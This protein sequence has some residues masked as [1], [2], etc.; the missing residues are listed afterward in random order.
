MRRPL[1]ILIS[2]VLL[3]LLAACGE[4]EQPE[5]SLG[6]QAVLS[7]FYAIEALM[8]D[9]VALD[10]PGNTERS[11]LAILANAQDSLSKGNTQAA[12]GQLGAFTRMVEVQSGKKILEGD[13]L[14]LVAS[15]ESVI[16]MVG[17]PCVLEGGF[18]VATVLSTQADV[19]ALRGC[20]SIEGHLTIGDP[21]DKYSI[22]DL[23][24]LGALEEIT[25]NFHIS[26]NH[27]LT[28]LEGLNKLTTS[29]TV[30]LNDNDALT[31]LQGLNNLTE[32]D[33]LSIQNHDALTSLEG[34]NKLSR[35]S[36]VQITH[37]PALTSLEGLNKLSNTF[38]LEIAVN[39][40]LTSVGALRRLNANAIFALVIRNNDALTNLEGLEG[41]TYAFEAEIH[42]NTALSTS[43][44]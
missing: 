5:E 4:I 39:P 27:A 24:P 15:G 6:T 32:T 11:L 28:S 38:H 23:T 13:A 9:V 7:P 37:N 22:V 44:S 35:T 14:A 12:L 29:R 3:G 43:H 42:D 20:T 16:G 40:S 36:V 21:S 19:E 18:L 26:S 1:T 30:K 41:V 31:N 2:L 34:L 33:Q 17:E 8:D 25:G 10:L